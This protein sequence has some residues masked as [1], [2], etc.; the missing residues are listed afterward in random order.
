MPK[1]RR[2]SSAP[3]Q[4]TKSTQLARERDE[5]LE[6]LSAA[7][8]VLKV[9]SSSPGDLQPVFQAMLESATRICGAKTGTLYLREGN[10]LRVV[11]LHGAPL[12][13]AEERQRHP[14]IYPRPTNLL[15][16]AVATKRTGQIADV[17]D[18]G[19]PLR[20]NLAKLAGARTVVAV[21]MVREDE[22]IGAIVIYRQ[23]VRPFTDKQITLV[24]NFAAQAVIAIEKARLLDELKQSLDRQ[25]ATSEVLS[26]ISILSGE[27]KPVFQTILAN[28]T[29]ISSADYGSL[30]LCEG[31]AYR[32]V[33]LHN[34]T[35]ELAELRRAS[36][37]FA[38]DRR[39]AWCAACKQSKSS[40]SRTC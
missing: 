11:A 20:T 32:V 25:I 22:S 7:S 14:V 8:D 31:D 4:E 9:I 3:N 23:E 17:Q 37:S 6:Q 13:Y 35:P 10:G 18:R 38:L 36:P 1:H 27:L 28:A 21:P 30:S 5:A 16:Q 33:A 40:K 26:V 2:H 12:A 39:A 29:R 24:Q 15:A 19:H 34:P